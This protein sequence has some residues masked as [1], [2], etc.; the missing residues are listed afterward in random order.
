MRLWGASL[1]AQ[2]GPYSGQ[3]R[4]CLSPAWLGCDEL[5]G[6]EAP[7]LGTSPHDGEAKP[8]TLPFCLLRAPGDPRATR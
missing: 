7:S 2:S 8:L 5:G 3:G 4:C 1:G 6:R